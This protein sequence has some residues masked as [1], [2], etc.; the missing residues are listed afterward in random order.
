MN[1][2]PSQKPAKGYG[3]RSKLFW[4]VVYLIAAV[5]VYGIIYLV[6]IHKSG[7]SSGGGGFNY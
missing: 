7:G 1:E 3:R 5:I 6:F 4:A 2:E